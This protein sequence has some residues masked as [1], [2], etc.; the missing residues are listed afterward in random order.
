V[1]AAA[2]L[3]VSV[4]K[5]LTQAEIGPLERRVR[6]RAAELRINGIEMAVLNA[7]LNLT[8]SWGRVCDKVAL[9]QVMHEAALL[10]GQGD[11]PRDNIHGRRTARESLR[12]LANVDLIEIVDPQ[13]R[14]RKWWIG[15][16]AWAFQGGQSPPLDADP[17]G[18]IT[19]AQGGQSVHAT[20]V[21]GAS[22]GGNH[23]RSTGAIT[24]ALRTDR[25]PI[26]VFR[27]ARARDPE[28][29][30]LALVWIREL[31]GHGLD[32]DDPVCQVLAELS[33]DDHVMLEQLARELAREHLDPD[34]LDDG[35]DV[36]DLLD[37]DELADWIPELL[38]ELGYDIPPPAGVAALQ[39]LNGP[40]ARL[41]LARH[42]PGATEDL[43][44]ELGAAAPPG[45]ITPGSPALRPHLDRHLRGVAS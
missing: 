2:V 18:A 26:E 25:G 17:T 43:R 11:P 19:P 21:I 45:G 9:E 32:V 5:R 30:H 13:E 15:I 6:R 29:L 4:V 36:S 40:R 3:G 12:A 31:T 1:A 23:P 28:Q 35:P 37:V 22:N 10:P 42:L 16:P 14:F 39:Q 27:D 20:G 8:T 24:P 33:E 38:T 34:C 7:C 44:L 41:L